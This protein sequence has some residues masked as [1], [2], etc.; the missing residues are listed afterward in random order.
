MTR[1]FR[2]LFGIKPPLYS[3]LELRMLALHMAQARDTSLLR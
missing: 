3:E 1:F 2:W